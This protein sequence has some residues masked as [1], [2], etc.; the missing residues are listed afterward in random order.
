[1]SAFVINNP[2]V[3]DAKFAGEYNGA[4]TAFRQYSSSKSWNMKKT[5][6]LVATVSVLLVIV[7]AVLLYYFLKKDT[8]SSKSTLPQFKGIL[9]YY[10]CYIFISLCYYMPYCYVLHYL[11]YILDIG[12]SP[13]VEPKCGMTFLK[14]PLAVVF[15]VGIK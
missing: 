12:V 15:I 10:C 11:Y 1:M 13:I 3:G 6:I 2:S 14:K 7:G 5:L 9:L 4:E 8:E